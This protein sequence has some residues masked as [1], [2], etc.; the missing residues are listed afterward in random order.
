[1]LGTREAGDV[2]EHGDRREGD[3]WSDAGDGL[4][5]AHDGAQRACLFAERQ[6]ES[7][8][9]R[10]GLA[11]H[12]IV[13][14]EVTG[15]IPG[16]HVRGEQARPMGIGAQTAAPPALATSAAQESLDGV[17]LRDFDAD[18]VAPPGQGR[19]QRADRGAGDVDD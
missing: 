13:V 18:E 3:D 10:G 2:G 11:P 17:D 16:H 4:E 1:M 9:L 15:K 5:P 7:A 6:I 14:L 19:A 12:G 8:E